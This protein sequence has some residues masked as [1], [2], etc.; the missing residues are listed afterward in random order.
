MIQAR[1]VDA[2]EVTVDYSAAIDALAF[3]ASAFQT[4]PSNQVAVL[5]FQ[6]APRI[7]GLVF[8]GDAD[9]DTTLTYTGTTPGIRTPQTINYT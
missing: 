8:P 4:L 6:V 7:L 5:R 1:I 9:T 2:T 3:T